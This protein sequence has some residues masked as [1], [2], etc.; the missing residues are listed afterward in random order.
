MNQGVLTSISAELL[1]KPNKMWL[2]LYSGITI[3]VVILLIWSVY[4]EL[5]VMIFGIGKVIPASE[6]KTVQHLEGGIVADILVKQGQPVKAGDVLL[7][8]DN[9]K[10]NANLGEIQSQ[11]EGIN[12]ALYRLN[13]EITNKDLVFE[14]DFQRKYPDI[15][16]QEGELYQQRQKELKEAMSSFR[17]QIK[18][19]KEEQG[20]LVKQLALLDSSIQLMADEMKLT[21]ELVKEDALSQVELLQSKRRFHQQKVDRQKTQALF[22]EKQNQ[23]S[24]I[25]QELDERQSGFVSKA[26]SQRS[27]LEIKRKGLVEQILAASDQSV[28]SEVRSPVTGTINQLFVNTIGGVVQPGMPLVEIVPDDDTLLIETKIRPEDIAFIRQ[29]LSANVRITAYDFS[30]YG[31]LPGKVVYI[32]ADT[33]EEKKDDRQFYIIHVKTE[34][35]LMNANKAFPILPGMIANVD[36]ITGKRTIF[37]Y[38]TKPITKTTQQALREK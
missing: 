34:S 7:K 13:A 1:G 5:D 25:Q 22:L 29:G 9:V 14:S 35:I 37:N 4:A 8:V 26:M 10:I 31:S 21:E 24:R 38:L 18:K 11:L 20:E 23:A 19:N 15:S 2:N 32:G 12:G 27:E 33:R 6:V 30:I 17:D 36:I 3:S 28:R 16:R